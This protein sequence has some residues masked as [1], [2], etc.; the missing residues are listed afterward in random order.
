MNAA[1]LMAVVS[2]LRQQGIDDAHVEVKA[3]ASSLISD[4]WESVS[5]FANTRGGVIIFGLDE[6]N[7]FTVVPGFALDKVRH[8]FVMGIGDG[9]PDN[10]V[11]VNAP[12][13][14]LE[15]VDFEGSQVLVVELGETDPRLKPCYIRRNGLANGAYKRID[16]EDVKLSAAEIYE[17]ENALKPSL[18]DQ[19]VVFGGDHSRFGPRACR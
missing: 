13:Y 9:G 14:E 8:Q 17:L 11:M 5:A 12:Q 1:E 18:A 19:A 16:D 4:V 15:R 10:C 2:R 7:G 6:K 3:G